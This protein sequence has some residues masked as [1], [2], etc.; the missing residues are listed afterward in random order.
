MFLVQDSIVGYVPIWGELSGGKYNMGH[1]EQ[2]HQIYSVKS[3][4]QKIVCKWKIMKVVLFR[5]FKSKAPHI[6]VLFHFKTST[7]VII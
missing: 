7:S 1:Q 6:K 2:E 5:E 4:L 3:M